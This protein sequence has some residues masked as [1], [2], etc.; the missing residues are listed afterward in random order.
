M[1]LAALLMSNKTIRRLVIKI[2][3]TEEEKE[4]KQEEG[5]E[6]EDEKG[7]KKKKKKKEK[8]T[9]KKE[10]E[11]KS[12]Q[13]R[14]VT[15]DILPS[16]NIFRE[17]QDIHDT[18]YFS[19]QPSLEDHWQQLPFSSF[20]FHFCDKIVGD[21]SDGG[22][23]VVLEEKEGGEIRDSKIKKVTITI[24]SFV[25]R[26]NY[27]IIQ[28]VRRK[29]SEDGAPTFSRKLAVEDELKENVE[30]V[31]KHLETMILVGI[32]SNCGDGGSDAGGSGGG[33]GGGGGGDG[34]G[35]GGGGGGGVP[36]DRVA[37]IETRRWKTDIDRPAVSLSDR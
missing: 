37:G 16:G 15:M 1:S 5:E 18:G 21:D 7:Q 14:H 26:Y 34:D 25:K 20:G 8:T 22:W 3:K 35:G 30:F 31:S 2:L 27:E 29:K 9:N 32:G 13:R 11:I 24:R 23:W 28:V 12:T 10:R 33:G 19:A 17:L 4:E 6:E 36:A